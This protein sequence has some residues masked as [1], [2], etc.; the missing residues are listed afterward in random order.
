MGEQ[1]GIWPGCSGLESAHNW[2]TFQQDQ[3]FKK[4]KPDWEKEAETPLGIYLEFTQ[5][6]SVSH[7]SKEFTE[8][9]SACYSNILPGCGYRMWPL[10]AQLPLFPSAS[11]IG[12]ESWPHGEETI[13]QG[14]FENHINTRNSLS[15]IH[16]SVE[17]GF[18]VHLVW[19]SPI[20]SWHQA[21]SVIAGLCLVKLIQG[22]LWCRYQP[23]IH[24]QDQDI[25]VCFHWCTW[26]EPK[27]V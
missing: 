15:F 21:T 20:G 9:C 6:C 4:L 1:L 7:L 16:P 2:G 23:L 12:M 14:H 11:K 5:W 22:W 26:C 10:A 3:N 27:K 17:P 25:R 24:N 18:C 13:A 19:I 8:W